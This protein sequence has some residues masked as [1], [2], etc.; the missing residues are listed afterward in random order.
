MSINHEEYCF[1]EGECNHI[2]YAQWENAHLLLERMSLFSIINCRRRRSTYTWICEHIC[3]SKE[4]KHRNKWIYSSIQPKKRISHAQL[5][6]LSFRDLGHQHIRHSSFHGDSR[7]E[8]LLHHSFLLQWL[9]QCSILHRGRLE[10]YLLLL[11]RR[12]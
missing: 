6:T 2:L 1:E 10:K 11:S 9:L 4:Q 7:E 5:P 12:G 8:P 3:C